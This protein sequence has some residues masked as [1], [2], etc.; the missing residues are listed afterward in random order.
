MEGLAVA[1]ANIDDFIA[2]IKAAPTPPVAKVDLMSRAWDSSV[3]REMLARTGDEALGGVNAF[4][5]ENLPKHYGIQTDGLYK[6]SDDQA[7]EILQMRLQRLTGLEQDKIVNEYKE[8]MAQ[9]ADLLDILAKPERVTVIITDELT[10]AKNDY[11][12]GNKD[13]RRSTIELNA[14]DLGTEDLITPQDMVVTLSHTGY[15]KAQPISEYLSLIH[16]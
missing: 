6:L 1:L 8:V 3:V 12:I 16:I 13:E 10:L 15:M 9:I 14:T 2:I 11:G 7:Q 4:R 5:P